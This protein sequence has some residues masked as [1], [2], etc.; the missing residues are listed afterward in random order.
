VVI[1]I[2]HDIWVLTFVRLA[3]EMWGVGQGDTKGEAEGEMGEWGC[4]LG[5]AGFCCVFGCVSV[6]VEYGACVRDCMGLGLYN[7]VIVGL[8]A[9]SKY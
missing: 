4:G 6:V 5:V 7:V 9:D 8:S 1:S 2:S 3:I